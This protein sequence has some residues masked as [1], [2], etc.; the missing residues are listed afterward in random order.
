MTHIQKISRFLSLV[1]IGSIIMG[2]CQKMDKPNLGDYPKDSNPPNGPLRF[3]VAFDGT[4]ANPSMNA[5]DSIKATFP[6]D[7]PLA[8]VEGV[9]GK[10][11]KGENKKFIKY[12]APNDWAI[13]AQSFTISF[14]IKR[15]GQTKNNTGTNGPEFP[16]SFKSSNGH[17]SG[18]NMFILLEGNNT[19]CAVKM[20][21]VDKNVSDNWMTWEGGNSIPG[22]LDNNWH[23]LVFVYSA[24][25]SK[26]TL[27]KDGVANSIVPG[28]GT[29]GN[30]NID[31]SVITEVRIGAGPGTSYDTDDWLSSTWKG[32]LDQFRMYSTAL[33]AAE[34]STLFTNKL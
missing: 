19:A 23:H 10:A 32:N 4:T 22:L 9:S 18:A 3:Y 31:N 21:V 27:Y 34:V 15:D 33:S 7:N 30:I 28:W 1:L 20:V 14:W 11:I 24:A 29:H 13:L 6:A 12:A 8:S 5:V 26:L 16:V 17:W 25:T 2:A